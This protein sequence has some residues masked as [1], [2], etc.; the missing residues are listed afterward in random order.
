MK[1]VKIDFRACRYWEQ[2][3]AVRVTPQTLA[4]ALQMQLRDERE[5]LTAAQ[6]ARAPAELR[7]WFWEAVRRGCTDP[8]ARS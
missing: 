4:P 3:G 6:S 1:N 2:Q 5:I 8:D 7:D